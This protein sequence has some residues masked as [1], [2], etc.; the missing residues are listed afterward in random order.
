[1]ADT[2]NIQ[3]GEK[4]GCSGTCSNAT[5]TRVVLLCFLFGYDGKQL[6]HETWNSE[7]PSTVTAVLRSKAT[8]PSPL[9][10][11]R[12]NEVPSI[13]LCVHHYCDY[14]N[15]IQ[16]ISMMNRRSAHSS[17]YDTLQYF[18]AAH[19]GGRSGG[20]G[21]QPPAFTRTASSTSLRGGNSRGYNPAALFSVAAMATAPV[22]TTVIEDDEEGE[23]GLDEDMVMLTELSSSSAKKD[24]DQDFD[25]CEQC[26]RR[27]RRARM[28]QQSV[29]WKEQKR[30]VVV[31]KN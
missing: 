6:C 28:L 20:G 17:E 24:L 27:R 5:T 14:W 22:G 16:Y 26:T 9:R 3:S 31:H 21:G 13:H 23:E 2:V 8:L 12:H 1:M 19:R 4:P 11:I 18:E 15:E 10:Q 29:I 7:P 30:A 25:L